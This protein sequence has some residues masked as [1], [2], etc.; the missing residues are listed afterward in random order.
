MLWNHTWEF[1]SSTVRFIS[2]SLAVF[3]LTSPCKVSWIC[4]NLHAMSLASNTLGRGT[5][6]F[7]QHG[8]I[9]TQTEGSWPEKEA[10]T[11]T[12]GWRHEVPASTVLPGSEAWVPQRNIAE[13]FR[14]R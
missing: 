13:V 14:I 3:F 10:N 12:T 8:R 4:R 7:K 5:P 1:R 6:T 11:E 9:K 2:T